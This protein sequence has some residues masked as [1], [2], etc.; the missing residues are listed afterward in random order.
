MKDGNLVATTI[1]KSIDSTIQSTNY[2][3]EL[4]HIL[5][6]ML[7]KMKDEWIGGYHDICMK[8][9]NNTFEP[10][11]NVNYFHVDVQENSHHES[12][13]VLEKNDYSIQT[14]WA[15]LKE[16][17]GAWKGCQTYWH[18]RFLGA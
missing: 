15:T 7:K 2:I 13:G 18:S 3:N 14:Q 6:H 4:G 8:E 10:L 5:I 11:M 12:N 16:K 1:K 9:Y 17:M